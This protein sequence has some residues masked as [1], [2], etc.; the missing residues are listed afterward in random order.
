M[1]ETVPDEGLPLAEV[2][3]ALEGRGTYLQFKRSKKVD[4]RYSYDHISAERWLPRL[5]SRSALTQELDAIVSIG[6]PFTDGD[7]RA[8][9]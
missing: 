1:I 2:R 8:S 7:M 6:P 4:P 9:A 3:V 5:Q